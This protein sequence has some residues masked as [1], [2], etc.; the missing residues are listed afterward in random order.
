[1][2]LRGERGLPLA[3]AGHWS[4]QRP[5]LVQASKSISCFQVKSLIS[6]AP[7]LSAVS[8]SGIGLSAPFGRSERRKALAGPMIMWVSLLN[9]A[10]P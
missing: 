4:W 1:M 6:L 5:Q 3:H 10:A 8:K 7:K 2:I 9:A